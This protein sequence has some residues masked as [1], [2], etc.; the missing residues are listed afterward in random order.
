M[1]YYVVNIG[2]SWVA[3]CEE[4]TNSPHRVYKTVDT[5]RENL[6]ELYG[7]CCTYI[8]GAH[9]MT[10]YHFSCTPFQ[11]HYGTGI[12][13]YFSVPVTNISLG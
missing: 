4:I 5:G 11:G 10:A 6:Q 7:L 3:S 13:H 8:W 12:K 1:H 2:G 9:V